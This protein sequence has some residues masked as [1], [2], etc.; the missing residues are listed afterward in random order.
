MK[1]VPEI[2][3]VDEFN[4]LD[5]NELD[6]QELDFSSPDE[7]L[8]RI[9]TV[10]L[11]L[12][13]DFYT[14]VKYKGVG[15]FSSKVFDDDVRVW[16]RSLVD[17]W[18]VLWREYI[19]G[20]HDY[21][22][23]LYR[24]PSNIV[25]SNDFNAKTLIEQGIN[26]VTSTLHSD[27]KDKATYYKIMKNTSGK[28]LPH[29]NFRRGLKRLTNQIDYKTQ[30]INNH[31]DRKYKEFVYGETA[32]F[33][34]ICSGINTCAWCYMVE[35]ESPLPLNMLPVDHPH[36]RCRVEPHNPDVFSSEYLKVRLD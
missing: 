12:Y 13:F 4:G 1:S 6:F 15:Y 7:D 14:L 31:I 3:S 2:P 5:D 21:Y 24:I 29:A 17:N 23:G 20:K 28:F 34:W 36:G 26:T 10:L 22:D 18:I 33:D 8:D 32:L 16:K 35:A 27:L 25:K 9:M 19:K 30:S 11:G